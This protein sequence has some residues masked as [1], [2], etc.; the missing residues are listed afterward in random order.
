MNAQR[1]GR[2]RRVCVH[3]GERVYGGHVDRALDTTC[4]AHAWRWQTRAEVHALAQASPS[5]KGKR[6]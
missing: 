4:G 1:A 2:P 6:R 5:K 3:C